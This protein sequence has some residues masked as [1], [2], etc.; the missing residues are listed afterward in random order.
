MEITKRARQLYD[1]IAKGWNTWDVASATANV[2]LPQKLRVNVAAVIPGRN[3]YSENSVW[4]QIEDFGEHSIDGLYTC[5]KMK[6]AERVWKIETSAVDEE[7]LIKVTPLTKDLRA[8]IVLEVSNI[9]D[10]RNAIAYQ[11]ND[12]T[13]ASG[14]SEFV[15]KSLNPPVDLPWNPSYKYVIAAK[16][17]Q[18]VYFTVNSQKSMEEIDQAI[19][20][21]Y[22]KWMKN[23]IHS[24]GDMGEAL[25]G[26]RRS[27]L[28]NLVYESRNGRPITPVSR[29][30][31]RGRGNMFGD[32]VI[33]GWDTFFAALSYGLF[34]KEMAYATYF[35]IL[36][37]I[38]PEGH[39]PNFGSGTGPSR[40]RS[41]PQ[42]GALC[43][44]KLYVQYGDKWFLEECFDRLLTWNRWRFRERDFNKDGL[45]E[46]G[47]TTFDADHDVI[48]TQGLPCFGWPEGKEVTREDIN[49]KKLGV[50]WESG[51][52]NS[53]MWDR[54]VYN[55]DLY[56]ME[57]TYAGLNGLMVMDCHM[58]IKMAKEIGADEEII[59]EL[60]ERAE[61]LSEKIHSQL[62]CEEK[63]SYL[64]RH[65]SGEFDPAMS[66][67]N[68]YIWMTESV[69][70]ERS[71]KML[72]HILNEDEFW[73]DYVIPMIARND[74]AY[75][76]QDYWRGRIWGP[77]NYLTGESLLGGGYEEV[78]KEL[79]QKGYRLFLKCWKEK[80][81][82]AENYN[83]I[84]GEAAEVYNSDRFYHWGS[85]LVYMAIQ[86]VA[87]FNVWEDRI[88]MGERPEWMEPV[89]GLS[90]KDSKIDI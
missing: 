21:A 46:L 62:W 18:P 33:F 90:V 44:W 2:L 59:R 72:A 27:L 71:R 49:H 34:S 12:V 38:T 31:C 76:D 79:A 74:P 88:K 78:W 64:N 60:T 57:I 41:E 35:S 15:I 9:W 29:N 7:L 61:T 80:G 36:E 4:D 32:Y 43:A 45:L 23:T 5:I 37:E 73:G 6:Y 83:A 89:W 67:T 53:P 16:D 85:L 68:F 86:T 87:N 26:M 69:S 17:D 13:A 39:V 10:G 20:E 84:T 65:W 11:G 1:S 51:L 42:V 55:K 40:D 54:A 22:A 82:V 30:W 25:C 28:W 75:Q 63:G 19:T 8:Y 50:M 48:M 56:C 81:L 14:D 3:C 70:Q 58:L 77:T 24:E 52:D 66:P 47:S